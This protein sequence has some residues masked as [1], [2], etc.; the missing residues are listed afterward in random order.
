[1]SKQ[2]LWIGDL[3]RTP[4]G[5][6]AVVDNDGDTGECVSIVFLHETDCTAKIAWWRGETEDDLLTLQARGPAAEHRAWQNRM[7]SK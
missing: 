1:M 3:V 7:V 4:N 2:L 6:L 5:E